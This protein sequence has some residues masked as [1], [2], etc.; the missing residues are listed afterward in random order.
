MLNSFNHKMNSHH[1]VCLCC[2][3]ESCLLFSSSFSI[4][5]K[6]KGIERIQNSAWFS[7]QEKLGMAEAEVL[8][9][10]WGRCF[11]GDKVS[12]FFTCSI[13]SS[14]KKWFYSDQHAE[15][16][17]LVLFFVCFSFLNF[18]HLSNR[19]VHEIWFAVIFLVLKR[20][21]KKRK[22]CLKLSPEYSWSKDWLLV[23]PEWNM[24]CTINISALKY[25]IFQELQCCLPLNNIEKTVLI[26]RVYCVHGV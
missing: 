22:F 10:V 9:G 12:Y 14:M 18:S 25:C 13:S 15:V 2:R 19:A 17:T 6:L 1:S 8:G 21:K 11:A 23:F 5:N 26:W 7:E 3:N 24:F 16:G 4:S 20:K